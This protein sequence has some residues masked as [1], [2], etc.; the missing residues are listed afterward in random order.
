M[1][2]RSGILLLLLSGVASVNA[3]VVTGAGQ[4]GL[5]LPVLAGKPVGVVANKAS[6]YLGVNTVDTLI[7]M[8]LQVEK[9]F[10]PEHGFRVSSG[11]G[12][13]FGNLT[14]SVSGK[15]VISLYGYRKKPSPEDLSG[16]GVMVFDLQDVGVRFYT[17]ISTLAGIM[18]ACAE[19]GIPVV[20]LDRPNPNGFY[21]DGPVLEPEYSSFAG[22]HPVPVVY[23]MTIAEYA[24]MV[25]GER[26]LTGSLQCDLTVIPLDNYT[27]LTFTT[28]EVPPSPNLGTM[29]AVYLYPSLCFFEGTMISV[30]RGTPY[31]FE[32]FG[33]PAMKG[34]SFFFI[35]ESIPGKS[36]H[37]PYEGE[38]C[39]GID[40]RNFYK[41]NPKMFGRIN[42]AWLM[43]AFRDMDTDPEFFNA[44]F[45]KL[46]G[47]KTLR[48]Q[49]IEGVPES[50]IRRSWEPGIQKFKL[51]REKYLLYP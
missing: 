31:P 34:F 10:S 50:E 47:T 22:L 43:M 25:N 13:E 48:R 7:A 51:I 45:D 46:A 17:Y 24:L 27:H 38:R 1:S 3:Q 5:Y 20:V 19:A 2:A 11:A 12:E 28:M 9:I 6:V 18:E 15:P 33:H 36:L 32:V 49:I 8:G 37:P 21:I 4:T 35:P 23:G 30:G 26:W 14:D 39:F 41:N 42:L 29:S 40:L 16:L 44:Y